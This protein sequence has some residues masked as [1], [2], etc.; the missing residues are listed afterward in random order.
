MPGHDSRP[1]S[2]HNVEC[3]LLHRLF[4]SPSCFL[5]CMADGRNE[6]V[7][8]LAT[9]IYEQRASGSHNGSPSSDWSAAQVGDEWAETWRREWQGKRRV[10]V[11]CCVCAKLALPAAIT[12]KWEGQE[13]VGGVENEL[14]EESFDSLTP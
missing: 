10:G 1:F 7:T 13:R 8:F 9:E 6:E 12:L 3:G 14:L 11:V 4:S 2:P 5:A